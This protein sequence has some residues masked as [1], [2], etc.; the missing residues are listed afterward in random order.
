MN[1]YQATMERAIKTKGLFLIAMLLVL[2]AIFLV[3]CTSRESAEEITSVEQLN[4]PSI[5][6][7]V[8]TGTTE[9]PLVEKEIPLANVEY[10]SRDLDAYIALT[11]GKIDA[12]VFDKVSMEKAI[13][14]GVKGVKLLDETLGEGNISGVGISPVT[15]IPDLENKINE[16]IAEVKEQG[17][18]DEMIRRWVFEENEEI[19]DIPIP[20]KSD[21]HL[22]VGTSGENMPFTYYKGTEVT[23]YDIEL[24]LRFAS[25][26]GATIEFKVYSYDALVI[27]AHTGNVDCIFANLFVTPERKES[28]I[29]SD[30]TFTGA[31]GIMVRDGSAIV[32]DAQ[33]I[34]ALIGGETS[35]G[36]RASNSGIIDSI[37]DSFDKTFIREGRWRL[38]VEGIGTTLLITVLSII[39]GTILGFAVFML[40]R[41]GNALVNAITRFFI[42]LIQGMP[43]VVLLMILYYVIFGNISI[44]G[45]IV[46]IFGFTLIFGSSVFG[47]L[48]SGVN[49]VDPGQTEAAYTLGYSDREAFYRVVFPQALPHIMPFYKG[50]ITELIKATAIVGYVAVQDLTKMGD[51]VR[52][53]TYEA[54]FPLI[55]VAI[56]Y[57]ILAGILTFLV[58]KIEF[59]I[60]PK[61]RSPKDIIKG[62]NIRK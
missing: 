36:E 32:S 19:P 11:Q 45:T 49:A 27:A 22:V 50:Q 58:N 18:M 30:P 57:F 37:K 23:G 39:F 61:R 9:G 21:I 44:S 16:F 33:E 14:H 42:W 8:G 26:L 56:I 51:I 3:S 12:F 1:R 17:I 62:I 29:F 4:S 7:G 46:S 13:Y 48:R 31:V 40:C 53:R 43:I 47:N 28:V 35:D 20:E 41:N 2:G 6:I 55:A 24:A 54:F 59:R 34:D 52:G 5:K 38:F 60:D 25:W 10:F 15:K